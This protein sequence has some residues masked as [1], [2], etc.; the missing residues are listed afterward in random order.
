EQRDVRLAGA[1]PGRA[2]PAGP[3]S[4]PGPHEQP[5]DARRAPDDRQPQPLPRSL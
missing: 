5:G 2:Y 1:S 3:R 4:G